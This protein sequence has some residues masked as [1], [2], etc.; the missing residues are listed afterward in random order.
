MLRFDPIREFDRLTR[1]TREQRTT[2]AVMGFDAVRDDDAVTLYFDVPGISADDLEVSVERNELTI[3]ATRVWK[4]EN[5]ETLVTERPQGSFTRRVML[6]D[7]LDTDRMEANLAEGVLE[8]TIPVSQ[9]SKP[10]KIDV[11]TGSQQEAIEVSGS[12]ADE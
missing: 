3:S 9:K 1:E 7:A 12:D 4:D 2:P 11:T 8:L 5:K 6:S 10:R